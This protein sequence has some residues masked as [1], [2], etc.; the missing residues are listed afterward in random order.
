MVKEVAIF[1]VLD[2]KHEEF[3][4]AV[5]EAGHLLETSE[6][7]ISHS[8]NRGIEHENQYLLLVEWDSKE[9]HIKNFVETEKYNEWRGK[10][11]HLIDGEAT[12]VAHYKHV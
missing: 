7:Y 10:I 1:T 12:K 6:G 11:G 3:E 8:L 4:K 2:G 9:A 5:G